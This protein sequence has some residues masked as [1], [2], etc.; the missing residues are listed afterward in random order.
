MLLAR[1]VLLA[2][3]VLAAC[4]SQPALAPRATSAVVPVELAVPAGPPRTLRGVLIDSLLTN[5]VLRGALLS[6]DGVTRAASTGEDGHFSFDSIVPGSHRLIVRH[7]LLDSLGLDTLGISLR[8]DAT[9]DS[10]IVSLPPALTFVNA[11]CAMRRPRVSEGMIIGVVRTAGSDQPIAD[12]EVLAGWR[13]T[14]SSYAGSGMR[15][16]LTVRTNESGQFSLCNPP[17]FTPVE[18]W[19][20]VNGRAT[21]HLR[22][23]L[24]PDVLGA[25]D[26]S[27]DAPVATDSSRDV[28]SGVV[29]GRIL[30]TSGDGLP[31]VSVLIDLPAMRTTT[32]TA[33]R[34]TFARVRPGV[35]SVEVRAIGFRPSTIGINLRPGQTLQRDITLDR[36][37]AVLG[38]VTVRATRRATWDSVGFE[39]R[40]RQGNGYFFTREELSGIVDLGTALRLVPGMRGRSND[41]SQRLVAGRGAGCFPAFVVNGIRVAAGQQI[42][43]EAMF[44]AEDVRAMEVYNS[45]LSTPPEYQRF[46]DCAVVVIW[47]RDP[48]RER[49]AADAKKPRKP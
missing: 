15:A 48:Q 36:T 41:R 23:Q 10:V 33:G 12:A 3:T 16:R 21:P 29:G 8:L 28:P 34:F 19:A 35:R 18:L 49:E 22:V 24:G 39:S 17:R 11:R 14:D 20:K 44:R 6:L 31:N 13:G 40:R 38:A 25:Y 1:G 46:V 47:L 5:E 42:G 7:P 26:L 27:V 9:A 32:D 45:R 37:V 43:P 30:T 2:S 4:Q